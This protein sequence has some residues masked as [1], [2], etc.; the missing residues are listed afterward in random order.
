MFDDALQLRMEYFRSAGAY[1]WDDGVADY[2]AQSGAS[3]TPSGW[4][5]GERDFRNPHPVHEFPWATSE[6]LNAVLGAGLQLVEVREWPW[7]NGFRPFDKMRELPGG[8]YAA[9]AGL[10]DLP[11]MFGLVAAKP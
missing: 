9:P 7:A 10:P 1:R 6:V 3:L 5:E 2:V 8:R 4:V 11:L